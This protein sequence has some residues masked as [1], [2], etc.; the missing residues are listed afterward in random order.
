MVKKYRVVHEQRFVIPAVVAGA[1]YDV[2][3][4]EDKAREHW[5]FNEW[6]MEN[7]P[8]TQP[9]GV[10]KNGNAD[11]EIPVPSNVTAV[12]AW[13]EGAKFTQIQ[14]VN[15]GGGASDTSAGVGPVL[16]V[17]KVVEEES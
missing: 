9:F 6:R 14:L 10:R 13:D 7:T 16:I 11:A 1:V 4:D 8:N 5:P 12:E 3:I 2:P 17:R 15:N